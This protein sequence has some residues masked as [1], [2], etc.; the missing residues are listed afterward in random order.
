MTDIAPAPT[1]APAPGARHAIADVIGAGLWALDTRDLELY[2]GTYWPD[3][4]F[5]EVA[6]DGTRASWRGIDDIRAM[7][8]PRFGGPTGRQHRL[9]NS[10]FTPLTPD[11]RTEGREGWTVWSYWMTTVRQ[12]GTGAAVFEMTGYLRDE[13]EQRDGEWRLLGRHLDAWPGDLPHPLRTVTG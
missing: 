1:R 3:A 4:V 5:S 10:L 9:S 8:E 11:R 12:P 13:V 7:T 6:P 2:L